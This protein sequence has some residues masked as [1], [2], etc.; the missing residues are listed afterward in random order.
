M[1]YRA[2]C[3]G[4]DVQAFRSAAL[5]ALAIN[6]AM[7]QALGARSRVMWSMPHNAANLAMNLPSNYVIIAPGRSFSASYKC[8]TRNATHGGRCDYANAPGQESE[9]NRVRNFFHILKNR[10]DFFSD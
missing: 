10:P 4:H 1:I 7:M 5:S 6:G 9:I 8:G 3:D 2:V